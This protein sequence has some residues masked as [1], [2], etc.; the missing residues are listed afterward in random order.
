[1][2]T[3]KY[4]SYEVTNYFQYVLILK[5][6]RSISSFGKVHGFFP[7]RDE[8]YQ[9]IADVD[10]SWDQQYIMNVTWRTKNTEC[11]WQCCR[12]SMKFRY[13]FFLWISKPLSFQVNVSQNVASKPCMGHCTRESINKRS[14]YPSMV[15]D[16]HSCTVYRACKLFLGHLLYY[17][18][19]NIYIS[20]LC[21]PDSH[22]HMPLNIFSNILF[23]RGSIRKTNL[24][25][26]F[27]VN[28]SF[29]NIY[30]GRKAF[31]QD[32]RPFA[33]L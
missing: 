6:L 21:F 28:V 33:R 31:W 32:T 30:R 4:W 16:Y 22:C 11:T 1:M 7:H 17:L 27:E 12:S 14:K 2:F 29:R 9:V 3:G 25:T 15:Y 23:N 13:I 5:N 18:I 8:M 19:R 20:W 10:S 26:N 24:I